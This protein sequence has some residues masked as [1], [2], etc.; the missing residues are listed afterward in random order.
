MSLVVSRGVRTLARYLFGVADLLK[1]FE[2]AYSSITSPVSDGVLYLVGS[3]H[4][5]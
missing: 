3:G 4:Q 1:G 5:I 2:I